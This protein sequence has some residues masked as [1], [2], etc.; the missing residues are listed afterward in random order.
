MTE[1]PWGALCERGLPGLGLHEALVSQRTGC[2][3]SPWCP[4]S[5]SRLSLCFCYHHKRSSSVHFFSLTPTFSRREFPPHSWYIGIC[6]FRRSAFYTPLLSI[7][8]LTPLPL[9]HVPL[10]SK[11]LPRTLAPGDR[12][13]VYGSRYT[14]P[15]LELVSNYVQ[16]IAALLVCLSDLFYNNNTHFLL[17]APFIG[18]QLPLPLHLSAPFPGGT[19]L[20][21]CG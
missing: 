16:M 20:P 18:S 10:H 13:L 19:I 9:L 1:G 7:T 11:M 2:T 14:E 21:P 6:F 3:L 5:N 15:K 8:C 12:R 4:P 17:L